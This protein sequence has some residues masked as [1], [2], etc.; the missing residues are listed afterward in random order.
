LER[1]DLIRINTP[2]NN[3]SPEEGKLSG[4]FARAL[5]LSD[6]RYEAYQNA[7]REGHDIDDFKH[8]S[9]LE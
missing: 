3:T 4:K 8:I 7:L 5:C 9:G 6:A 1:R 2:V